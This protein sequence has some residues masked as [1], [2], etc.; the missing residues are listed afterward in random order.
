MPTHMLPSRAASTEFAVAL[1]AV[2]F[3]ESELTG[4]S[5]NWSRPSEVATQIDPSRPSNRRVHLIARQAIV[6]GKHA[7]FTL[8][9]VH[10][11]MTRGADPQSTVAIAKD[12]CSSHRQRHAMKGIIGYCSSNDLTN[13]ANSNHDA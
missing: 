8:V 9:R 10:E 7:C 4:K 6:V 12:S 2:G 5:R 3:T 13:A 1:T 11:T